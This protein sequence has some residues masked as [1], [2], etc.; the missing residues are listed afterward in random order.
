MDLLSKGTGFTTMIGFLLTIC[1]FLLI[2]TYL[3]FYIKYSNSPPGIMTVTTLVLFFSG[4]QFIFL[5][6]I[7]EYIAKIYNQS[8]DRP[9]VIEEHLI[10]FD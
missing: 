5:G 9:L 1:S 10:G 4:I 3:I 7:G 2:L 8:I 6:V